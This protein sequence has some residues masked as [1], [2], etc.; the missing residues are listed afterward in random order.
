M[1]CYQRVS[2]RISTTSEILSEMHSIIR[3]GLILGG[4]SL[5][6]RRQSVFFTFVNPMDDDKGMEETPCNLTK[7]RIAPY[8]NT[9][10]SHQQWSILVK[11]EAHSRERERIAIFVK[12]GHTQ[13]SST[14][15]CLWFAS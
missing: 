10:K 11:I 6:R 14:T 2:L 3:G 9:W 12:H 15:H 1:C 13:T 8:K 7:P 5:K 4:R